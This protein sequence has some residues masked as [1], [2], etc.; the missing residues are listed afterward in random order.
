M[1]AAET[2]PSDADGSRSKDRSGDGHQTSRACEARF[3][4]AAKA[5]KEFHLAKDLLRFQ[6]LAPRIILSNNLRNPAWHLPGLTRHR[7]STLP[8]LGW[9][10]RGHIACAGPCSTTYITSRIGDNRPCLSSMA[11][12]ELEGQVPSSNVCS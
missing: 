10:G 12:P 6:D 1:P 3:E 11:I 8:D 7:I 5:A 2:Y 4:V 9:D